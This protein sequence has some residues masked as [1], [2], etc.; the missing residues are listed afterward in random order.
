MAPKAGLSKD[1]A[2]AAI[3]DIQD[4]SEAAF[5][6]VLTELPMDFPMNIHECIKSATENRLPLLASAFE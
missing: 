3:T 1:F 2:Q 5:E 4:D 6:S